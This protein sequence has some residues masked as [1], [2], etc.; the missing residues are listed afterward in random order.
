LLHLP[1]EAIVRR[2]MSDPRFGDTI[3]DFNLYL[4]GFKPDS[5]K[6][7][8]AYNR[9]AF[10]FANAVS[11]AQALLAG[12]DYFKVFDLEG[13]LY[14][15]PLR[16]VPEDP[17]EGGDIGLSQAQVRAKAIGELRASIA[18]VLALGAGP[19]RP[20]GDDFC[21]QVTTL[22]GRRDDLK[23]RLLRAFDDAEIFI[24]TRGQVLGAPFD[25]LANVAGDEC[26]GQ[27]EEDV[28]VPR[29]VAA[30]QGARLSP[31]SPLNQADRALFKDW[32]VYQAGV[33]A[34]GIDKDVLDA[35]PYEEKVKR[36]AAAIGE[37][38]LP[39]GADGV[40]R[41]EDIEKL[42]DAFAD[43]LFD[44]AYA[45]G[46][47]QLLEWLLAGR[48]LETFHAARGLTASDVGRGALLESFGALDAQP[49][50]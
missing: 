38:A 5:L 13:P 10:D 16:T 33:H 18:T 19:G 41:A 26:D 24:L 3:L 43:N 37:S 21:E 34:F 29:L 42:V 27:E 44:T 39:A 8:G 12:G 23:A 48:S 2:F 4:L 9:G 11:A 17:P 35:L 47:R 15:P 49:V 36:V 45:R 46:N 25:A 14:V 20:N 7:D 31:I 6:T 1:E 30:L 22:V 40:A 32:F 28:N 50:P